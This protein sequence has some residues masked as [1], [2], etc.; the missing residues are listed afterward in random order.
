MLE[1]VDPL[2]YRGSHVEYGCWNRIDSH[3]QSCR[4][5][6]KR[7][8]DAGM[9]QAGHSNCTPPEQLFWPGPVPEI[10]FKRNCIGALWENCDCTEVGS[11]NEYLWDLVAATWIILQRSAKI[12]RWRDMKMKF[13]MFLSKFSGIFWDR[14]RNYAD[15]EKHMLS[16]HGKCLCRRASVYAEAVR[17][18]SS[19]LSKCVKFID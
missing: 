17:K 13:E 9:F 5:A 11:R 6:L 15:C 4:K 2:C 3:E 19:L 10:C 12:E 7:R 18:A 1:Y 16:S 8:E 14:I